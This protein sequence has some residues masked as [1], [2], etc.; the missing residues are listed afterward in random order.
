MGGAMLSRDVGWL[1]LLVL[2]ALYIA[3][4]ATGK[5]VGGYVSSKA[6]KKPEKLNSLQGLG[7]LSQGGIA[8]AM[9]VSFHLAFGGQLAGAILTVVFAAIIVN[10]LIGP[11]LAR[12]VVKK[13]S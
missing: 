2:S 7:L 9:A 8:A 3:L 6:L 11:I 10:E 1:S 13:V 12:I 5:I 4:R